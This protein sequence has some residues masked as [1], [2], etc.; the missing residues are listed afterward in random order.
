MP[1]TRLQLPAILLG[2]LSAASPALATDNAA[3]QAFFH[4]N[5]RILF[6]GDSITDG[7]R[8]RE[9]D[10]LNHVMGQ[11]YCYL[12]AARVGADMPRKHLLFLNRGV[13]SSKIVDM[14]VRWERDVIEMKPDILSI[15]IGVNDEGSVIDNWEP[16]VPI[17]KYADVYDALI[18]QTLAA[19]PHV[20]I[21]L[22]DP[23]SLPGG[24]RTKTH[25]PERQ[26]D[27][28]R[29]REAVAALG[30]KYNF[31]VVHF[32]L[33]FDEACL[34]APESTWVW[35]GVHPTYAGHQLMADEWLRVASEF[36]ASPQ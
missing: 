32:Q 16:V 28:K 34:S 3:L 18:Q 15:L 26:A 31:P 17:E 25:W 9:G 19:L 8:Q 2:L 11:D 1:P 14:Q 7:G 12:I 5:D 23:F 29:R 4:A 30:A 24:S 27:L 36:Y 21:V 10:D 22:C 33:L 20:R 35:D 6:E 13:G